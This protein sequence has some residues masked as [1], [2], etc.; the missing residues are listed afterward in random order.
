MTLRDLARR[1]LRHHW[2]SHAGVLAGATVAAAVLIGA[3]AVGDSVKGSL[4]AR[5]QERL[6]F[7]LAAALD[8]RDRFVTTNLTA[9]LADQFPGLLGIRRPKPGDI[10]AVQPPAAG[11]LV[12]PATVSR[13]DGTARANSAVVYGIAEDF[14]NL[15]AYR[16]GH[17]GSN[18]VW[19][20]ESLAQQLGAVVGDEL[21]FRIHKP[22]ALSRDAVI[23]PRDD[24]SVALRLRVGRI[25]NAAD[26]G[27]FDLRANQAP[28]LNAFVDYDRLARASGLSGH[29]NLV[30]AQRLGRA[31]A[32]GPWEKWAHTFGDW[33]R[34]QWRDAR[35]SSQVHEGAMLPDEGQV[36]ALQ[37][38]LAAA[39]NLNDA[40]LSLRS[41][42]AKG[43]P[44]GGGMPPGVEL[45]TR[46]IFLEPAVVA[47]ALGPVTNALAGGAAVPQPT[48]LITYLVNSIRSGD[49]LVPYSMVTAAGPPY[50]PADLKEDE[51]VVNEWLARDLGVKPGDA[52]QMA[53]YRADA[54]SRLVEYTNAFRV[55]S[56]VPLQGVHADRTLMPEFPGL[57]KA[58]ST[59]DWDAGFDLVHPIRDV[60]EAYWKER[61]GTPKAFISLDAGR[62][63]WA[64][65]FGDLTAVRWWVP[66]QGPPEALRSAV[67]ARVRGA[68]DPADLGLVW[69]PIAERARV[70]ASTGQDFGGLFIG[71]SIFLIVA[72]LL[73]M[74]MMFQFA[75]ERR[76]GEV[77]VLLALG[78][79]PRRVRRLFLREGMVLAAVGTLLGA[80][81]GV[82][83]AR[84]ILWG[85]STIWSDAVART[86][87]GFYLTPS[88]LATG[89]ALGF[90]TATLTL[91]LALRGQARRPARELLNH[92]GADGSLTPL[93]SG[94]RWTL[95]AAFL[96][97]ILALSLTGIGWIAREPQQP[98]LF[99]GAGALSLAA[100]SLG[101]RAW[102]R[103]RPP[104]GPVP[105]GRQRRTLALRGL[106][107][108]PSRS[109]ATVLL[110]AC[111]SFLLVVVAANRLDA[112]RKAT[113]RGS[114]TG[115]FAL[116]AES[117]LPVI[118]NLDTT[119][120][121]EFYGLD[122]ASLTGVS[123]VSLRVR[124]G[125]DASCLNLNRAQTPRLLGVNPLA[126]AQRGAF[127]FTGLA[128]GVR[129]TNGW[130]VL[131]P[132]SGQPAS[133]VPEIPAIGDA[134]SI[135]WALGK[136]LGD[137]LD[138]LDE[139]GRP[140]R[141]RL[142]GAVASSIL[143]GSLLMSEESFQ[144]LFPSES[145]YRAFL[146][147]A[148]ESRVTAVSAALTRALS[149][150]GMQVTPATDRL[151]RFHAVQ[152]TYL[153]TFQIL[154]GLGLILGSVGLGVVVLRNVQERRGE[155]ALMLAVGFE[156]ATIRRWVLLEHVVLLVLGLGLG[157]VAA[158]VA[159]LPTL[160][161][162][163]SALPWGSLS[164]TLLVVGVNGGIWTWIAAQRALGAEL[165]VGLREL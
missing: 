159:V 106:S 71:F 115:G 125:D 40:E 127:T 96:A 66:D 92:G 150:T 87:L 57:T 47:A 165:L 31:I 130:L 32:A 15:V 122:P 154:G 143:Q 119:K 37:E 23:T 157:V 26:G 77:G 51:V 16:P 35:D 148:P 129:V 83:Y 149:D 86:G 89:A 43:G 158:L 120:G 73:L 24:Q 128:P 142:A 29:I 118:Q 151:A 53:F 11:A 137:T 25:L 13:H 113:E 155:L 48:P 98:A 103:R 139:R 50:T 152:N 109:L 84:G 161:H 27:S 141:I 105:G 126:L 67:A 78:W 140:F 132:E 5:M 61:R 108:H 81:V 9:A 146:I 12:L 121:Q 134:N 133:G 8:L 107:R 116:W 49:R 80:A 63:M 94:S 114:G 102:L 88:T 69:A 56:V 14:F 3:L 164:V 7:R 30:V 6:G 135:Q 42:P 74:A 156:R 59:R 22:S 52:I 104:G 20:S 144:R 72:A 28:A 33:I 21:V 54:G 19:L 117:T 101:I 100:G 36:P 62:R 153:N 17:P 76:T 112:G 60:D 136:K 138:F 147:D 90:A 145:G 18:D 58:E 46:R 99:F 39:W 45:V 64:N 68:L 163:G 97:G 10:Y 38:G 1:S 124:D 123:T 111:A 70:A 93:G 110:L 79:E 131:S 4:A 41:V 95:R 2:R 75:L 55:R 34:G 162:S 160:L 44:D 65:R 85:L 82:G 91:W